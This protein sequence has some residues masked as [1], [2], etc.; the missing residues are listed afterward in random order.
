MTDTD[1]GARPLT[2]DN[3]DRLPR[4]PLPTP[5]RSGE[6]FLQ[7]CAPLLDD[8]ELAAT[9]KAVA[10]FVEPDGPAAILHA[11]LQEYDA[12]PGVHSWL[13]EFWAD[14]Y[15]GRRDRIA[16]NANFF[17]LF[18]P[19][20]AGRVQ[21]A[22]ELIAATLRF[23]HDVDEQLLAPDV[24]R[25]VPQSMEQNKYL[26]SATR[27]PGEPRDTAR[28][29]YTEQHPGPSRERH[30]LVLHRGRMFRLDAIGPDGAPHT[31]DE[32]A[33]ALGT[34]PADPAPGQGVGRLTTMARAEWARRRSA[35]LELDPANAEAIETVETALF[36][37][38]LE[39]RAPADPQQACDQLL[40][41]DA[42]SRWFD[43]SLT[44]VVFAD[45]SAGLNSEHCK[46][47]GT[48]V[49]GY[50]EQILGSPAQDQS[51]RSGA[52]AQ[53]VP[54][55]A[56]VRFVL[57]EEL[58][59]DVAAAG[60]AFT[61]YAA[62]TATT[63]VSVGGFGSDRAK[64]LNCSPDAFVQLAYQLAQCRAG[65]RVGA[66]YESIA[67][68]R[69]HHGRTEAMRVVTPE[70]VRFTEVMADPGAD[71]DTRRAAVRAAAEAHVA[72]AKACQ[73]GDAPE[74]HLWEL[75]LVARRRGAELGVDEPIALFD[76]PGWTVLRDDLLSTSSAPCPPVRFF[77][78]GSTSSCCIG[79]GYVLMPDRFDLYLSTPASVAERMHEFGAQLHRAVAE[80]DRLLAAP[81]GATR[82]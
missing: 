43:K 32:L 56:P 64:D 41:G 7:W 13:D 16:L 8:A 3:E 75:Q 78:F 2:F 33:A 44:L 71:D 12:T 1:G 39:D 61:E 10:E 57:D 23:K 30:V 59:A 11:A 63:T 52:R 79:V 17:F 51:E 70:I 31:V 26:F 24:A 67:T 60:E 5:Q 18:E 34:V 58:R 72:R 9:R 40:H 25:G 20:G 49:V 62:A 35:L 37:L 73:A 29:P 36:C 82:P 80:L 15:L 69:F 28:L 27:I 21:R 19:S 65:G 53:G 45:G 42:G 54:S 55:V 81:A 22:A 68:R 6:L 77:G 66:T 46:L 48:T 4:V 74:Q 76:S 38:A 47:D 14:R 50:V